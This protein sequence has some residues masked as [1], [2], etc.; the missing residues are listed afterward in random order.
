MSVLIWLQMGANIFCMDVRNQSPV[1]L[2]MMQDQQSLM[3]CY[4]HCKNWAGSQ[5]VQFLHQ[6]AASALF[7]HVC[8][9]S[10]LRLPMMGS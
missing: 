5:L 8:N 10:L 6:K 2:L 9:Q 7:M 3:L 4:T 1:R